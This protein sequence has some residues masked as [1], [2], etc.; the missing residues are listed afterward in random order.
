VRAENERSTDCV[1]E[2]SDD[3][4]AR[5]VRQLNREMLKLPIEQR[6]ARW[7]E[8]LHNLEALTSGTGAGTYGRR[9]ALPGDC[10]I[11]ESLGIGDDV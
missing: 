5:R 9:E 3:E 10:S 6:R 11:G 1:R 2:S 8:Y 4:I 7:L